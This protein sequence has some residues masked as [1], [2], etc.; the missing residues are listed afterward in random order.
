VHFGKLE[1]VVAV[2]ATV[3]LAGWLSKASGALSNAQ[4]A[5]ASH[6]TPPRA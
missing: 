5:P 1:V 6:S 4:P 3:Y 2:K